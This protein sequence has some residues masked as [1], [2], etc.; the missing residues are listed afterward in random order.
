MLHA[1]RRGAIAAA[2]V[3]ASVVLGAG[4]NVISPSR[5]PSGPPPR[6]APKTEGVC[7]IDPPDGEAAITAAIQRCPDGSLVRFPPGRTYHQTNRIEVIDRTN[8]TIDGNGSTFV[9]S[10]QGPHTVAGPGTYNGNWLLLRNRDV[11]VKNLTAVG[12]FDTPGPRSLAAASRNPNAVEYNGAFG[13]YGGDGTWITDVR[14]RNVW[15]DGVT[16]A[17]A[18]YI[19]LAGKSANEPAAFPSNVH[20]LRADIQTTYRMCFGPTSGVGIWIE[21]SVCRDNWYGGLDAE[22]DHATD[23]MNDLHVLRNTF[24]GYVHFGLAVPVAGPEIRD[25]EIRDNRFLTAPDNL[26]QPTVWISVW[27]TPVYMRQIVIEANDIAFYH[28]AVKIDRVDSGVV[29]DNNLRP[30]P[31]PQGLPAGG[32]CDPAYPDPIRVT[33]STGVIVGPNT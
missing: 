29:R 4:V 23:P 21:D 9:K 27:D 22:V 13:V 30:V 6:G 10:S 14:A 15:G 17:N 25:V 32:W 16:L 31:H 8:I 11:M 12:G 28:L 20:I 33:N 7:A 19:R 1:R 2:A 24:D 3:I 18:A 26:C 5:G